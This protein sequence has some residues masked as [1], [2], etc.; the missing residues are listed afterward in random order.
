[1]TPLQ[2]I[3]EFSMN[4]FNQNRRVSNGVIYSSC[5]D[6]IN[7][8][9]KFT[10]DRIK[11]ENPTGPDISQMQL[12]GLEKEMCIK[13]SWVCMSMMSDP[14]RRVVMKTKLLEIVKKTD[15]QE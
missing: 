4:F 11:L 15:I 9:V 10:K 13:S 5:D 8:L 2:Q 3:F 6:M 12:Y 14:S 7:T 1:M